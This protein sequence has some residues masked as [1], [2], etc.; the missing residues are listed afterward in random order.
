MK[1]TEAKLAKL[2]EAQR[3]CHKT[4]GMLPAIQ[5]KDSIYVLGRDV[6]SSCYLGSTSF[7][8]ARSSNG[9]AAYGVMEAGFDLHEVSETVFLARMAEGELEEV[10]ADLRGHLSEA[11]GPEI[12]A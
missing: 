6:A 4:S 10:L 2:L 7:F 1:R 11:Y 5:V 8:A 9:L 3:V 12:W